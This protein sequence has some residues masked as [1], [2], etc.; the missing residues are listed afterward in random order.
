MT[1]YFDAERV[2]RSFY[3]PGAGRGR[4]VAAI[5]RLQSQVRSAPVRIGWRIRRIVAVR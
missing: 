2:V 3:A 4:V 1:D 5:D